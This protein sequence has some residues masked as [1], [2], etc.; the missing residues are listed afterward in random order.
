MSS[1]AAAATTS[2][3]AAKP[4]KAANKSKPKHPAYLLMVEEAIKHYNERGGS[5]RAAVLNYISK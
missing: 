3:A 2:K 1:E 5:S 4:K